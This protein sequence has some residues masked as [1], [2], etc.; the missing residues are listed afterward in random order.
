MVRKPGLALARRYVLAVND[1]EVK[2]FA[3]SDLAVEFAKQLR[4][5]ALAHPECLLE[6]QPAGATIS[7]GGGVSL[8]DAGVFVGERRIA[9]L[10]QFIVTISRREIDSG[11][12]TLST[13]PVKGQLS[14]PAKVLIG[15]GITIA[16]CMALVAIL[17]SQRGI[18]D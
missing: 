4:K 15:V 11:S 6:P 10:H 9:E 1:D 8:K 17:V 5:A 12:V 13:P 2:T 16:A 14:G 3:V 18:G 7:L